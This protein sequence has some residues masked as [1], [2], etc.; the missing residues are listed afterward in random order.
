M[1][2]EERFVIINKHNKYYQNA[3]YKRTDWTEDKY[4]A[5]AFNCKTRAKSICEQLEKW[6]DCKNMNMKV[7][8]I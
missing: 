7:I 8:K 1:S 5:R 2:S 3:H 4:L 6:D